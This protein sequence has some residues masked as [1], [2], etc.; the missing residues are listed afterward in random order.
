MKK[1]MAV[2]RSVQLALV[3]G[4][5]FSM[6]LEANN[7]FTDSGAY[8]GGSV[9]ISRVNG[10]DF[11]DKDRTI[12][13][14]AGFKFNDHIAVESSI[15]DFGKAEDGIYSSQL[16]GISIAAAGFLPL[17][18]KVSLFAKLGILHWENKV[19]AKGFGSN[20]YNGEEFFFAA[21]AQMHLIDNFALRA[22]LERFEIDLG[23]NNINVERK[24][25]VDVVSVGGVYTF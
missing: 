25:T 18:E 24:Y 11:D 9:G 10:S 22:E 19:R 23:N 8:A 1:V 20:T 14:F 17:N 12:K 15:H 13:G 7:V 6:L 3:L 5:S 2:K 4:T 16:R 21:G